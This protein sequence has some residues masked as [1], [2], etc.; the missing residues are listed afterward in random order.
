MSEDPLNTV[1]AFRR[2]KF[3]LS[4]A[5]LSQQPPDEG[6]EIAFAGRSNSGKSSMLNAL[7]NIKSLA[8]TSKTPGRTQLINFFEINENLRLVDLPG[9][10]FASVPEKVKRHW[11]TLVEGY[12]QQRQA[13]LGVVLLMDVRRPLTDLDWQMVD[14]CAYRG[15]NLLAVLTKAD[16][17]SKGAG[18]AEVLKVRRALQEVD[19]L[20]E[21]DVV[22]ASALKRQGLE[23]AHQV[24]TSWLHNTGD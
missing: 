14:W 4:V 1:T 5:Q 17:V 20:P 23:K 6:I 21:H 16:K 24:L 18:S 13:L 11:A 22:L 19:N 12:L 9:Y 15:V 3:T 2:A 8:R 10:G 7:T